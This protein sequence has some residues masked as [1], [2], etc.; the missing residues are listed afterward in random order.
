MH[1]QLAYRMSCVGDKPKITDGH[2]TPSA[3]I[4]AA[5]L[6]APSNSSDPSAN[7]CRDIFV[8]SLLKANFT[9]IIDVSISSVYAES[10]KRKKPA[11]EYLQA[12]KSQ[13]NHFMPLVNSADG[14]QCPKMWVEEKQFVSVLAA[15]LE[16]PYSEMA[17]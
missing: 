7:A 8:N 10:R 15:K 16:Q 2:D 6:S 9:W 17:A 12:C 11:M 5:G 4:T 14:I 13:L 3:V 1:S